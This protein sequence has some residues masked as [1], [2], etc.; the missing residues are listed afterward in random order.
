[1]D[2]LREVAGDHEDIVEIIVAVELALERLGG[3]VGAC[4]LQPIHEE[5]R[6][7]VEKERQR[8]ISRSKRQDD[9]PGTLEPELHLKRIPLVQR[10]E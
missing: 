10:R 1:V 5:L 4:P 6:L 9:H 2:V 3:V 8:M 7:H